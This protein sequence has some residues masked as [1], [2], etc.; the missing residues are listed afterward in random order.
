MPH[1]ASSVW[2]IFLCPT[3]HS[4]QKVIGKW[5]VTKLHTHKKTVSSHSQSSQVMRDAK[6]LCTIGVPVHCLPIQLSLIS[7]K[8]EPWVWY[9]EWIIDQELEERQA[10][11]CSVIKS[12]RDPDTVHL[13][14]SIFS[15][16]LGVSHF[17]PVWLQRA[18]FIFSTFTMCHFESVG[19]FFQRPP[20]V[21]G[22]S[23]CF[24]DI[25]TFFLPGASASCSPLKWIWLLIIPS[26]NSLCCF[27]RIG[28]CR[29]AWSQGVECKFLFYCI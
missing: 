1:W 24:L 11:C 4:L 5:F 14:I 13:M 19:S 9:C 17:L 3:C 22:T 20:Q 8:E 16:C 7:A 15:W 12:W 28:I 18:C 26:D 25:T 2:N 23:L 21:T 27:K 29:F 6:T 10:V